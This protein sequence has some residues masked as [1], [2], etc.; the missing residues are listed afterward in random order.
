MPH[1]ILNIRIRNAVNNFSLQG[2]V[3]QI[4]FSCINEMP[5]LCHF[6]IQ[7]LCRNGESQ[8]DKKGNILNILKERYEMIYSVI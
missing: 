6:L 8:I 1:N 3:K 7:I 2:N 5:V 4:I